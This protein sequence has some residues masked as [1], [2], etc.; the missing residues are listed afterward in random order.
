MQVKIT[1]IIDIPD[2]QL[3]QGKYKF[4]SAKQ[5]IFDAIGGYVACKHMQD[6]LEWKVKALKVKNTADE[7]TVNIIADYHEML[8][9]LISKLNWDYEEIKK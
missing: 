2:D 1:T 5:F 6:K 9:S 7:E 4:L 8:H 3:L